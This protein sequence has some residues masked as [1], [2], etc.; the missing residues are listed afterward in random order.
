M[1]KEFLPRVKASFPKLIGSVLALWTGITVVAQQPYTTNERDNT[2]PETTAYTSSPAFVTSFTANHFNAYNEIEWSVKYIQDTRKFVIQYST[3]GVDYL[4]AGEQ[5]ADKESYTLQHRT[6]DTR[7]MFYR[8][9]SEQ[10]NGKVFYSSPILL[11][12]IPIAPVQI[13]PTVVTGSTVNM[14]ASWPVERIVVTSTSGMQMLAKDIN[15]QRDYMA[16]V[17][18][19]SVGKGMYYMTF[20]GQGW[21]S[22][23]KF[24]IP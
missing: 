21:K 10:L 7:P 8:I 16:V 23:E 15:G 6:L 11:Q 24:I 9:R 20:Y 22:T 1:R 12:G 4:S 13:Y 18:P 19:T 17:L 14:N 3:D 5:L 2:R